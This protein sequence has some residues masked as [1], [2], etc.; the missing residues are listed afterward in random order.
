MPRDDKTITKD[1]LKEIG[2]VQAL[3]PKVTDFEGLPGFKFSEEKRPDGGTDVVASFPPND[4]HGKL[5]RQAVIVQEAMTPFMRADTERHLRNQQ[6][7]ER[8]AL[9]DEAGSAHYIEPH[10][11]E[12]V[13]RRN[14][15]REGHRIVL[16][17]K[18][19]PRHAKRCRGCGEFPYWCECDG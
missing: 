7:V 1:Q 14:G 9:K 13:E 6:M 3:K 2:R 16:S 10:R 15:W 5:S 19:D 11:A 4:G 18:P 8:V 17:A 12:E